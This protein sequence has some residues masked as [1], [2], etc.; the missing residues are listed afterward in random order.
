MPKMTTELVLEADESRPE[1]KK[2]IAEVVDPK[3]NDFGKHFAAK[4]GG[5]LT[6]MEREVLRAYT[7]WLLHEGS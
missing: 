4:G 6:S 2:M 7:W 3:I 1:P 5:A